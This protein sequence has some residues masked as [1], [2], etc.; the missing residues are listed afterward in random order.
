MGLG[1]LTYGAIRPSKGG[2]PGGEHRARL[3]GRPTVSVGIDSLGR[4]GV[5]CAEMT[6]VSGEAR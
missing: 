6:Q 4:P 1:L 2:E 5:N 3:C